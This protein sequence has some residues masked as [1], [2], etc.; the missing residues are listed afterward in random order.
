MLSQMKVSLELISQES[1]K[2][3]KKVYILLDFACMFCCFKESSFCLYL[4][5][6]QAVLNNIPG[7]ALGES[8]APL[9]EQTNKS[10]TY[11]ST[12]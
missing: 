5:V 8:L 4:I 1:P 7:E 3:F 9:L 12:D 11:S 6:Q 2:L 10:E